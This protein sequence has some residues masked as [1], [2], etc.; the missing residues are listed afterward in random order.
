MR[1]LLAGRLQAG[2]ASGKRQVVPIANPI[3]IHLLYMTAW[4]DEKG[5]I[6]FRKDIYGRD[7]DLDR[8]LQRRRTDI[9]PAGIAPEIVL[10]KS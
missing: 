8:A 5:M 4:V 3:P 2:L 7:R 10:Q 6:Q 9:L 1:S